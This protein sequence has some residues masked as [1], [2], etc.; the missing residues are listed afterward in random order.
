[1]PLKFDANFHISK[2]TQNRT[3]NCHCV[4]VSED[5]LAVKRWIRFYLFQLCYA[6][7][8][9][10]SCGKIESTH[11]GSISAPIVTLRVMYRINIEI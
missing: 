1:M 7:K 8:P 9:H 4:S 3:L 11:M 6:M 2:A 5:R 10:T